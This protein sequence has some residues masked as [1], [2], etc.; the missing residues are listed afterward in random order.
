MGLLD[1]LFSDDPKQQALIQMAFGL[2][3]GAPGQRKNLGAD[4]ANAGLMGI[5]GYGQAKQQQ[6]KNTADERANR[7]SDLQQLTASY[8]MLQ[9]Q[10]AQSRWDAQ[11]SGNPYQANPLL[12]QHEQKLG[13]LLNLPQMPHAGAQGM[14]PGTPQAMPPRAPVAPPA[15]PEQLSGPGMPPPGQAPSAPPQT[16]MPQQ[17]QPTF[18]QMLQGAGIT[19]DQAMMAGKTQKGR[20]DLQKHLYSVYGPRVVNNLLMQ[21]QPGGGVTTLGG[22]VGPDTYP[23]VSGPNGLKVQEVGGLND[24]RAASTAAVE[25]AKANYD[26]VTVP[27]GQGGTR[28]MSRSQALGR[29]QTPQV[30]PQSPPRVATLDVT[31]PSQNV[32]GTGRGLS[33][34]EI[35]QQTELAKFHTQTFVDTQTAGR[36]A[37]KGLQNLDRIDQ[38]MDGVSTGKL[39]P[40][41]MQV[42]AYAQAFGIPI[43]P[44]LPN[45]QAA[46]AL[47]A[48]IALE[49][50]NP[51]GGAGMPGAMSD[52]DLK[53]LRS[54]APGLSQ[55]TEGRKMIIDSKRK[56]LQRDQEVSQLA[57]DYR[58]KN[59]GKLD[60]GFV[61]TLQDY[62]SAHPLFPQQSGSG[63]T[64]LG[65]EKN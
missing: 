23:V 53:F 14:A 52:N 12:A 18:M 4:I 32:G 21:I 31:Q 60:D 41:G 3:G 58:K 20:E 56:I 5:Q 27:D 63:F 35:A 44:K 30:S 61:Q 8:K 13:Q 40:T 46:E 17:Q 7:A 42:S 24:A 62:S 6:L 50:R 28:M 45:K 26:L 29:P 9:D 47:T 59:G 64:V 48:Q 54:M 55:T 51:A 49:N 36:A 33:P 65:V 38:L 19:P 1:G 2:L 16:G 39:T 34:G 22:A 37:S 25:G 11:T 10:D 43:D 57:R 15:G